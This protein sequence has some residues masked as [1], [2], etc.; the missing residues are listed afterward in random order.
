MPKEKLFKVEVTETLQRTIIVRARNESEA[1][2]AVKDMYRKED[3]VLDS[4]DYVDTD[5]DILKE[6]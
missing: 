4:S 6:D 3:I 1:I 2:G 5:F